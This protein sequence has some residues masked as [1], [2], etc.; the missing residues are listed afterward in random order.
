ML[1]RMTPMFANLRRLMMVSVWLTPIALVVLALFAPP[2]LAQEWHEA[3][4]SIRHVGAPETER[5]DRPAAVPDDT[6]T[7]AFTDI[8]S[9]DLGMLLLVDEPDIYPRLT[10]APW[11]EDDAAKPEELR[12][13]TLLRPGDLAWGEG[14]RSLGF[15]DSGTSLIVGRVTTSVRDPSHH[16]GTGG[17][18]NSNVSA[19][20]T[21]G[22]NPGVAPVPAVIDEPTPLLII[23]AALSA[24]WWMRRRRLRK[25]LSGIVAH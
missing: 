24:A 9:N 18:G 17:N 5:S 19:P 23:G 16:P 12:R 13:L 2:Y 10:W 1:P 11:P 4:R 22:A 25:N 14:Q 7:E 8:Q 15:G 21:P 20:E 6:Q 3:V